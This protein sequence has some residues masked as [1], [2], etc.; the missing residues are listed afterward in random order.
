MGFKRG[1]FS[2]CFCVVF[3]VFL[4]NSCFLVIGGDIVHQ[5]N[6]APH[7]P[8]CNNNFVL[9]IRSNQKDFQMGRTKAG[10]RTGTN[11]YRTG[12]GRFDRVV[13]RYRDEPDR[14]DRDGGSVPSRPTIYRDRTGTDRNGLERNG[15]G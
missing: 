5:D 4:L 15:M 10:H 2:C 8:G 12:M 11:R 9:F 1:V 3:A 7:R 14:N 13:D 6:V